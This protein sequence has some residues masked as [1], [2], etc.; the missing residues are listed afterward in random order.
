MA[1]ESEAAHGAADAS[2]ASGR[3]SPSLAI[4][5]QP[6]QGALRSSLLQLYLESG[7]FG[8]F[9]VDVMAVAC[10]ALFRI[11]PFPL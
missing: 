3:K 10:Q 1:R 9:N 2:V 11:S 7:K 4:D 5:H 8:T 6:V